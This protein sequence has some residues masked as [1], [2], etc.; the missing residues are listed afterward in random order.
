M[1]GWC[2]M[3]YAVQAIQ[4]AIGEYLIMEEKDWRGKNLHFRW[5]P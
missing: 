3:P 4:R 1:V 2:D 5:S